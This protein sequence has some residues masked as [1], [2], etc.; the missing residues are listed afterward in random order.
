[1]LCFYPILLN[2]FYVV[3]CV[4]LLNIIY[5]QWQRLLLAQTKKKTPIS[6]VGVTNIQQK[7]LNGCFEDYIL[8]IYGSYDV[9]RSAYNFIHC[10]LTNKVG[11]LTITLT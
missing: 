4:F 5:S 9:L 8:S 1:M 6:V 3:F 7:M 2:L 11:L 10:D